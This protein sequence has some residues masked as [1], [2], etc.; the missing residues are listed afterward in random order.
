MKGAHIQGRTTKGDL[1]VFDL[2][3]VF[4][5]NIEGRANPKTARRAGFSAG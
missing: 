2:A 4:A 5:V 3:H 1:Y